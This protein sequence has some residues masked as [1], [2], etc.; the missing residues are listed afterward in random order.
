MLW[1]MNVSCKVISF[2][3][4]YYF[5]GL[6]LFVRTNAVQMK[7]NNCKFWYL[8][9]EHLYVIMFLQNFFFPLDLFTEVV[10]ELNIP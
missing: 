6:G 4:I 10:W 8:Q 9:P 5:L 1:S 2:Y 7:E 3:F